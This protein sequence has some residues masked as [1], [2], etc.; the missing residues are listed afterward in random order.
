[1]TD[2]KKSQ[3]ADSSANAIMIRIADQLVPLF[4]D[5]GNKAVT[6]LIETIATYEKSDPLDRSDLSLRLR[7]LKHDV[8]GYNAIYF[9]LVMSSSLAEQ[10]EKLKPTLT[11]TQKAMLAELDKHAMSKLDQIDTHFAK[12]LN[13]LFTPKGHEAMYGTGPKGNTQPNQNQ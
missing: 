10:L 6:D 3:D 13:E 9:T 4:Q 8:L 2:N 7:D 11:E 1:M 12:R 5:W